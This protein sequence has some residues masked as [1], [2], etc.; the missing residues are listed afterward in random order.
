[1]ITVIPIH[2]TCRRQRVS[3]G[4]FPSRHMVDILGIRLVLKQSK[5]GVDHVCSS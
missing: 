1:M 2:A 5:Q 4:I 3:N